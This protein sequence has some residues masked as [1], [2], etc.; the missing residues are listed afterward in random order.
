VL[1][2]GAERFAE[3]GGWVVRSILLE[4]PKI[5]GWVLLERNPTST[6]QHP[7][8]VGFH[9]STQ[10]TLKNLSVGAGLC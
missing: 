4:P 3:Y 1:V 2:V 10:P 9:S 6:H 7:R 5:V 8:H